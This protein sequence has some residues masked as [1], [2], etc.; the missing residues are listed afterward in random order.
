MKGKVSVWNPWILIPAG[1][2]VAVVGLVFYLME[3]SRK[4]RYTGQTTAEILSVKQ[5]S[6]Y[7]N[8]RTT[9]LYTPTVAYT[10]DGNRYEGKGQANGRSDYYTE[11]AQIPIRYNVNKPEKCLT[12]PAK[13]SKRGA[14]IVM[15]IGLGIGLLGVVAMFT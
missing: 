4:R 10:I 2:I 13:E 14:C 9:H 15:L 1:V 6:H 5:S 7:S 12:I 3:V 11:G 8:G